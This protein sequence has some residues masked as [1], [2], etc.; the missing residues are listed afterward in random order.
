[1]EWSGSAF[2]DNDPGLPDQVQAK[3]FQPFVTTKKTGMGVGLSISHS[4]ITDHG[5]RLRSEPSPEGGATFVI[6]LPV[7]EEQAY[8]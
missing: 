4:I 8:A 6:A 1:M 3:L 7:A 5:G 2:S